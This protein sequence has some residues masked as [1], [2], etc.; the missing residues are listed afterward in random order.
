M[1]N[2]SDTDT[3]NTGSAQTATQK[4]G[5]KGIHDEEKTYKRS[6]QTFLFRNVAFV[7]KDNEKNNRGNGVRQ[8]QKY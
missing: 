4:E 7:F 8:K 1:F 3:S 5:S 6:T 2:P